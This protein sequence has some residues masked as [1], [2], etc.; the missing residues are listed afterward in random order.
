MGVQLSASSNS[1][2]R[3]LLAGMVIGLAI[4]PV[5]HHGLV[6]RFDLNPWRF[7]GWSMYCLPDE[8]VSFRIQVDVHGHLEALGKKPSKEFYEE[9]A[10]F[11]RFR[12]VFRSSAWPDR[13][14]QMVLSARPDVKAVV[15]TLGRFGLDQERDRQAM[16]DCTRVRYGRTSRDVPKREAEACQSIP[17]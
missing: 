7:F 2:Q 10:R 6:N 1:V 8:E 17:H 5:V 3:R 15:M 11:L 13:L 9:L 16:L 14:A 4:W 12:R